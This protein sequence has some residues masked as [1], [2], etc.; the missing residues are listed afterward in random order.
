MEIDADQ[1]GIGRYVHTLI[2]QSPFACS[3]RCLQN[4]NDAATGLAVFDATV[5]KTD[6]RLKELARAPGSDRRQA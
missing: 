5:Q 2:Q 6:A 3:L 1:G 4:V